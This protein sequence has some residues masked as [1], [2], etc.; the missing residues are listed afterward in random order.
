MIWF[1]LDYTIPKSQIYSFWF[2]ASDVVTGIVASILVWGA[3]ELFTLYF[4][5]FKF[6]T[7][8]PKISFSFGNTFVVS[9]QAIEIP[10][11]IRLAL[12]TTHWHSCA[13]GGGNSNSYR[14]GNAH[15]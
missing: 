1:E 2:D 12:K 9:F 3:F 14:L 15:K 6:G 4:R 13:N 7:K 10:Q 11:F 5:I 8:H